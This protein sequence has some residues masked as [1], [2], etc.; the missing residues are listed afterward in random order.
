M[1]L[2]AK[3]TKRGHEPVKH[4]NLTAN[5]ETQ[6]WFT[7]I[8]RTTTGDDTMISRYALSLFA[9]STLA[10]TIYDM[11]DMPVA[12]AELI[13]ITMEQLD[14]SVGEMMAL[15]FLVDA[16]VTPEMLEMAKV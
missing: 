5:A 1:Y 15:D 6:I 13:K 9:P 11:C 8:K 7:T 14:H 3:R 4:K 10:A 2:Q 12:N 16:G